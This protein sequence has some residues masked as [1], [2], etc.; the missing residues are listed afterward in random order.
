MSYF[1]KF[2][3]DLENKREKAILHQKELA[4][5][6]EAHLHRERVRRYSERWQNSV[7]YGGKNDNIKKTR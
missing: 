1:D 3:K 4:R 7:R 6:D 5:D 2:M